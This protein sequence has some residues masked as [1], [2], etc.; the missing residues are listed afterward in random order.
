VTHKLKKGD[1]FLLLGCDGVWET[2]S[3]LE[4]INM[5]KEWFRQKWTPKKVVENL[6]VQLIAPDTS[7]GL[8]CDN[9]TCIVVDL[10]KM[11]I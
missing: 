11:K 10:R 3:N 1:D 7:T 2:K 4:I 6:L 8:G 5:C 9:M